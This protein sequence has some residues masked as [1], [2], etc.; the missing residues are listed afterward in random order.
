MQPFAK[1]VSFFCTRVKLR[2]RRPTFS[3]VA[4]LLEGVRHRYANG[5]LFSHH[6]PSLLHAASV[7][8]TCDRC[9]DAT[10]Q[11]GDR[12]CGQM[13]KQDARRTQWLGFAAADGNRIE[14]SANRKQ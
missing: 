8:M 7:S 11:P 12:F 9:G 10:F 3:A 13:P 5:Y 14:T 1:D 4:K 2:L 6:L